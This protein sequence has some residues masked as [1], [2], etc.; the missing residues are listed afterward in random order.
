MKKL[1]CGITSKESIRTCRLRLNR[2]FKIYEKLMHIGSICK[3]KLFLILHEVHIIRLL[4]KE[5]EK[6]LFLKQD[7]KYFGTLVRFKTVTASLPKLT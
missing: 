5:E 3:Q 4:E 2:R 1:L 6:M 7:F